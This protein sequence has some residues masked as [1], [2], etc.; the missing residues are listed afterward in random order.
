MELIASLVIF[1]A[2]LFAAIQRNYK[3]EL[4]LRINPGLVGLSISYALQIT[5]ALNF[6]VRMASELETNIVAVER[7]KEYS[8]TPKETAESVSSQR[9]PEDWPPEGHVKF[10]QYSTRYREDLDLVL[11]DI[12]VDIPG[13]TKV[14]TSPFKCYII[15]L[16][17][18]Q[19]GI[20]GR[21]GA[22]KSSL[23][24]SMFRIIEAVGG[25]ILIDDINLRQ[26]SLNDLRSKITIIPQVYWHKVNLKDCVTL[27]VL[28][29]NL[30]TGACL[31]LWNA[32]DEP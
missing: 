6:V 22:G 12:D 25:A 20:V 9:P 29:M 21:T 26:L 18:P 17:S 27:T 7:I 31:F 32:E 4:N 3:D 19:V 13:G 8:E 24:L 16:F 10:D 30:S 1:F 28:V 14:Y 15:D 2:A 5:Q 23:T 11:K